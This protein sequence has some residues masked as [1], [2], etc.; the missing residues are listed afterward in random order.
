MAISVLIDFLQP[1]P[2]SLEGIA[3]GDVVD[4]NDAM[5]SLIIGGSNGAKSVLS[6]SVPLVY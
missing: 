4:D 5:C 1:E 3:V 2:E 6:G